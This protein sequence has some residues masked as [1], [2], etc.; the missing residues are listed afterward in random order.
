MEL[1]SHLLHPQRI[2]SLQQIARL[3]LYNGTNNAIPTV[4]LKSYVEA[5]DAAKL[6]VVATV[7]ETVKVKI[8]DVASQQMIAD[9][10]VRF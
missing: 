1:L 8:I 10:N 2:M 9:M 7:T 5:V 6:E 3:Y 4:G